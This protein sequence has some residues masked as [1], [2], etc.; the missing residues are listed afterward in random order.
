MK[1]MNIMNPP[2]SRMITP[3]GRPRIRGRV[4]EH[5]V[6]EA[7]RGDEQEAGE[8]D[9]QE[10]DDVA[11]QPLLGGQGP[12]L[13]LDPDPLAD[14]VGDR[15]EDLGEV[16]AD[17]VLD[18]DGGRHELEVVRPHAADHVLERLVERQAEVH[19]ADDPANS[20]EIG[21]RDSRTTSSMACRNDEPARRALAMSVIVSGSCLLNASRRP[22]LRRSS[23]KR[24][25]RN[26][27]SAADQ[28]EQRVAEGRQERRQHE[29][30]ERDADDRAAPR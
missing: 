30:D 8:A 20:V 11:R 16:A 19:L 3:A 12:D 28:Q 4:G 29:H 7:G 15:V 23:Q 1:P 9:R 25:R 18:R 10:A 24:G 17:L 27:M 21:G 26:P 5:R 22:L 14:R 2:K 6:H 13:A